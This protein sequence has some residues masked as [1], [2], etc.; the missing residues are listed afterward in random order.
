MF[1]LYISH[2]QVYFVNCVTRCY[3]QFGDPIVFTSTEYIKLNRL[4]V[5]AW[6]AIDRADLCCHTFNEIFKSYRLFYVPS[7][8]NIQE[9]YMVITLPLTIPY[10][11]QDKPQVFIV[12]HEHIDFYNRSGVFTARYG[13]NLH[14]RQMRLVFI[15]LIL[16]KNTRNYDRSLRK[17]KNRRP[18]WCHLL[19]YFTSYVLNMLRTLKYP[20]SGAC[21]CAKNIRPLESFWG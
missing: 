6:R 19:F 11:S 16:I 18:T 13:L 5:R 15:E 1:R 14:R 21:D 10:G 4:S 17:L 2:P 8:L 9:F 7:V 20:S 3:A 12:Q